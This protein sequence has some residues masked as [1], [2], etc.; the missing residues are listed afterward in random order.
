MIE[1]VT[2]IFLYFVENE[3]NRNIRNVS[4]MIELVTWI[5]LYFVENGK[6]GN[7]RNVSIMIELVMVVLDVD[8]NWV[9]MQ[10]QCSFKPCL[11]PTCDVN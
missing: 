1:L 2:Q 8:S 10:K 9:Q 11:H 5:F 6:N 3:K 4:I 7:I